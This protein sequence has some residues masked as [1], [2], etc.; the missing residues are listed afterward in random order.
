MAQLTLDAFLSKWAGLFADN[1]TRDIS[2]EDMRDFRE[3]IADSFLNTLDQA[4]SGVSGF[5]NSIS[6]I[7]NLKAVLTA[8][9]PTGVMTAFRDS[10]AGNEIRFYELV[11]GTDA[12]S[13]PNVVRPDDYAGTTNEKVWKI[14]FATTS[15]S[16]GYPV[17]DCGNADLSS[18]L[19]PTTGGTGASGAIKRG[20]SF[21]VSVGGEPG[22]YSIDPNAEIRALVDTPGQTASNWWIRI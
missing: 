20:N 19:F 3:D 22:G 6:T 16:V 15:L 18:N 4:Y 14:G 11:S 17:V 13:L 9:L 10:S 12:E 8:D 5:K 21:R 2:E 7:T 1:A